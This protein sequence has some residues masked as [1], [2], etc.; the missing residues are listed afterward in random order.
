[1]GTLRSSSGIPPHLTEAICIE[2][3]PTNAAGLTISDFGVVP[4]YS[5]CDDEAC[6]FGDR[7]CP[8]SGAHPDLNLAPPGAQCDV[9]SGTRASEPPPP[10]LQL[11]LSPDLHCTG[12]D[13]HSADCED[14]AGSEI[15]MV[16]PGFDPP[17]KRS[18]RKR[19]RRVSTQDRL[20]VPEGEHMRTYSRRLSAHG[21]AAKGVGA[22]RYQ[23]RATLRA[24]SQLHGSPVTLADLFCDASLLGRALVDDR[25]ADGPRLSKWTLAQRR[26][27]IR[28][29]AN[30][31]RP[32]LLVLLGEEPVG[33]IDRALRLVA[34]R[35]GG[36]YR[37]TGGEPRRRGGR[38]PSRDEATAVLG[39]LSD[40]PAFTGF[41]NRAFFSILASTGCRVNALRELDGTN[42]VV[43]PNG[44][45]RIYLHEKGKTERREVELSSDV[46]HDFLEYTAAFNRLAASRGW[47]H[48]VH[49]GKPGAIWRNSAGDRWGYSSVLKALK[50]GCASAGVPEF[51]P[52]AFRRAFA[53]DAAGVLPRHVVAQAG[54]WKGLD[55]LDDHYIQPRETTIW[56]KLNRLG[57]GTS[58]AP[59]EMETNDAS[60]IAV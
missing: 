33:V 3:K 2:Q 13:L 26:S 4:H 54:G 59:T 27:A 37:L 52:H 5:V 53:S 44:R 48:R 21:A 12:R 25:S 19:H 22:Y 58:W 30:L 43:L 24:A 16:L 10:I 35:I 50:N 18:A 6:P 46:A 8:G 40:A 56:E 39:C 38:A 32:E 14:V 28:S 1:M 11:L 36:G 45:L 15:Q 7:D 49:T 17:A 42:C 60:V 31:M 23:L 9:Q 55:R 20:A 41:R 34:E 51:A 57:Q 47:Q 29:F